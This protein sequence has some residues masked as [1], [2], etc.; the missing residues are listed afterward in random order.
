M[1]FPPSPLSTTRQRE[2]C[3]EI[4]PPAKAWKALKIACILDHVM[5]QQPWEIQNLVAQ[6]ASVLNA[7]LGVENPAFL[8]LRGGISSCNNFSDHIDFLAQVLHF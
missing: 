1:P 7:L 4:L 6:A 3:F 8:L 2:V 5:Q